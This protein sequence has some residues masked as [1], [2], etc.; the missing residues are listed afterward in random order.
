MLLREMTSSAYAHSFKR[1]AQLAVAGLALAGLAACGGGGGSST[2]AAT[3][4]TTPTP[5]TPPEIPVTP[6]PATDHPNTLAA[7]VVVA[8]GATVEGSIDSSDDVDFFKVQL[9]D[10]GTVT[11]WTT[12]EADTV[13]TLLDGDGNDLSAAAGSVSSRPAGGGAGLV[14]AAA[15]TANSAGRVSVTTG[16]DEVFARVSGRQGGSTGDYS[17]HNEVVENLAPRIVKRFTTVTAKAGGAAATVDLSEF[18]SDPEGGALTFSASLPAGS[19]GPVSLG[20]TVSGSVLSIVGPANLRPGP[21]SI[22]VT[23]SDPFGLVTVQVLSV[24]VQPADSAGGTGVDGCVAVRLT[25]ERDDSCYR[26]YEGTPEYHATFTNSCSYE[27]SVRWQWRPFSCATGLGCDRERWSAGGAVDVPGG[28]TYVADSS[29]SSI[30][31]AFRFC[32]G[33]DDVRYD[34]PDLHTTRCY[35]DSPAWREV[36]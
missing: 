20:L 16:L 10:P 25:E 30:R 23:A 11:F 24:T 31:P 6:A 29:C 12:G 13:I 7:A 28:G 14:T 17:L 33:R 8:A 22:T 26:A 5:S 34:S 27:V 1:F 9:T 15:D 4:P 36:N 19:I 3:T 2:P 32:V 18:F 21:V 35:G